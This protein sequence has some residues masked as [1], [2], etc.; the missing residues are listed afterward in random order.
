MMSCGDDTETLG[1]DQGGP[2]AG[3]SGG[4]APDAGSAGSGP[5]GGA[6]DGGGMEAGP[7]P[8]PAEP[9]FKGDVI[10]EFRITLP[11]GSINILNS[12][13]KT[14][15]MADLQVFFNKDVI[16]LGNIGIRLK[17]NYGS[18][19]T[20]DQKAAFLLNFDQF[21]PKQELYGLEKLALN[22]MVQDPSMIHERLSYRLFREGGVPAPRSAYATVYVNDDL[23]G[24]YS[25]VETVDNSSYL[26]AWF[27]ADD[28]SLYEGSYGSDLE[29]NLIP[30]FD[31][32]N[33][34]DV[35]YTDLQ[36]LV[37]ALNA[38]DAKG[39]PAA[40]VADAS[41]VLNLDEYLTFAA[42]EIFIGHWDGYAWTRNNFFLYRAPDKRWSFMPWGTDQI[43]K[44]YLDPWGGGGRVEQMCDASPPCRLKLKEAFEGVVARSVDLKLI[45]EAL[46]L[47]ALIWDAATA[48][49]RKEVDMGG[50]AASIDATIEYLKN[51]P[52]D[53][54]NR[55]V[56]ADP[57]AI[58]ND[59][60][61]SPG[62]GQDC[63][64]N[65]PA[66]NPEAQE[67]CDLADNNC[68]GI[69]DDDPSCPQCLSAP[70]MGGGTLAFCFVTK[71]YS[72]AEA[73]CVAQGGHLASIHGDAEQ[74]EAWSGAFSIT[75]DQWWI[76][77]N[78]LASEGVYDWTDK[79]PFDHEGWAGGEP[80]DA[81][82]N[83]DCVHL[84]NWGGGLWNDI[85]CQVEFRYICRLP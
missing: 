83:E 3:G 47:K 80:N 43:F 33:G 30:T 66:L 9:F 51:R 71:S 28:G 72:D 8:D 13:P 36:E 24:L 76:G 61:G 49:P 50:I 15:V 55:L 57:L 62:C 34:M 52:Q 31:H 5:G 54:T 77:L 42:T 59:K 45:E 84:A 27:G 58:D 69:W 35:G 64:D 17:G 16:A 14:Y 26:T 11:P 25:T 10:P 23:Y 46:D 67:V 74:M 22:N 53:V 78:D 60:D 79:T 68:N 21:T 56:C 32:D 48:D 75:N 38:I 2:G 73:D 20:L 37:S 12:S 44:E 81:G 6:P 40:F 85:P 65:D 7:P 4:G 19:R 1:L 18:F 39:D 70:A 82:G 29:G 41:K 63:D